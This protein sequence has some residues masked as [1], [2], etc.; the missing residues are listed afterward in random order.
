MLLTTGLLTVLITLPVYIATLYPTVAGGDSGELIAE[1]CH[2][3]VAHPP[4]YPLYTLL[5]SFAVNGFSG[6]YSPAWRSN[7][8][9]GIMASIASELTKLV[10]KNGTNVQSGKKSK[11]Q[12]LPKSQKRPKVVETN[13]ITKT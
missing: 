13:K 8:M 11:W 5:S 7:A 10:I 12:G 6:F 1:S 4:G 3:G 9:A 2:L